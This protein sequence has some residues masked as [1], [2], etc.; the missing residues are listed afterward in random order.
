M[1]YTKWQLYNVF[2][3]L[4]REVIHGQIYDFAKINGGP[5]FLTIFIEE[6]KG[7]MDW[8]PARGCLHSSIWN[9]GSHHN[10]NSNPLKSLTYFII[11]WVKSEST[12][13]DI[14]WEA[15]S[16]AQ[17]IIWISISKC[18]F[19]ICSNAVFQSIKFCISGC[20]P[21]VARRNI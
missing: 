1:L 11:L 16:I 4:N 8:T 12:K 9:Y 3:R 18:D 2:P 14:E 19:K 20:F 5:K 15:I 7:K 17:L 21:V 13:V 6:N 10:P